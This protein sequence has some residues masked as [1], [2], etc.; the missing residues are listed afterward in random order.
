MLL[1]LLAGLRTRPGLFELVL[2]V[3]L[4]SAVAYGLILGWSFQ[5]FKVP[6]AD[7]EAGATS[8]LDPRHAETLQMP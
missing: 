2:I 4:V 1:L 5:V 8:T 3:E 6:P 7:A